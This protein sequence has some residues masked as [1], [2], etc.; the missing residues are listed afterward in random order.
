MKTILPRACVIGWPIGHSRSPAI[1]NYWLRELGLPGV[2]EREAVRSEE[3]PAFFRRIGVDGLRGANVTAPHKE[4]AHAACAFLSENAKATGAVNTLWRDGGKLCGDNSDVTGFAAN[5][6]DFVAGW[7]RQA[8]AAIVIGAGG[9]ARAVVYS[10]IQR[11]VGRV[12]IVNRTLE[13]AERLAAQF[14]ARARATPWKDL[15]QYLS[16]AD[17]LVN[18]TS[19]GMSGRSPLHIDLAPLPKDAIVADIVYVPLQTPLIRAAEARGLRVVGGLG[20]LLHQAATGFE[21][22]FGVRP[23]VSKALRDYIEVDVL[24]SEARA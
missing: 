1:H 12:L 21:R 4:S 22:W 20:M 7:D 2:Y 18:A 16:G 14:G 3:L 23:Q 17:M 13:R 6:D 5:L 19:A 11:G 8:A 24:K 15:P 9:A 10:L